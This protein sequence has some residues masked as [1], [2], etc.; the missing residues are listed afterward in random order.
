MYT[1]RGI[2][3]RSRLLNQ[4]ILFVLLSLLWVVLGGCAGKGSLS[5]L[6]LDRIL[7]DAERKSSMVNRFRAEFVKTRQSSI[8]SRALTVEGKLVF[9]KPD[10]FML[11]TTGDVNV[12]IVS[13]GQ[14]IALTHDRRDR[15]VY[16]AQGSRDLSVL[17]DPLMVL[18]R[19][20]GKGTLKQY[21]VLRQVQQDNAL[22][23]EFGGGKE[24]NLPRIDRVSLW[25][26]GSGTVKRIMLRFA[27]GDVDDITFRSWTMLSRNAPEILDLHERLKD[28]SQGPA[29]GPRTADAPPSAVTH[30][31]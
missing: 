18:I 5:D 29:P 1:E 25:L 4:T 28:L 11:T 21:P 31:Y 20:L 3:E 14:L 22:M 17:A 13:D 9:Q 24:N 23:V 19:G 2:S 7:E 6:S 27:N 15:E 30:T 16:P 8:F 26:S 12:E 10:K